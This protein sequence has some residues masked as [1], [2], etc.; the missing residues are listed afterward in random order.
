MCYWTFSQ[1]AIVAFFCTLGDLGL[2]SALLYYLKAE[3]HF[4][5]DQFADLMIIH[6]IGGIISQMILLPMLA[7][8]INEEKTL[9]IGLAFNCI[10]IFLFAVAWSRWVVYLASALQILS[11]LT[12]PSVSS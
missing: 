3:F 6:G 4:D 10:H 11:E 7:R 2:L 8:V 5:K 9:A 12:G 1:A